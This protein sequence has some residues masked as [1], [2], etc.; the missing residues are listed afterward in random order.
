MTR[1]LYI[2][3]FKE[4]YSTERYIVHALEELGYEV[5]AKQ[6]GY[7]LIT[8]A[9]FMVQE[10]V[11]FNPALVMFSK[12]KPKGNS[13]GFIEGLKKKGIPTCSWLFDLYFDLPIDRAWRLRAKDAPFNCDVIYTTDGGHHK[14]F[15]ELGIT[16]KT[17][18]QGIHESEA[19]LYDREKTYDV[20]FVGGD[21]FKT[22]VEMLEGLANR[23]GKKFERFGDTPDNIVRN[24]PLNELYAST[25]V[26][27]GDSQPSP[28]Y[29]SNR[30]YETLGRGGFLLHPKTEGIKDEFTDGVHLVLYERGDLQDLYDK[31]DYYLTHDEEREKIR[32]AG[33]EHVKKNYTYKKRCIELMKNYEG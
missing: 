4:H 15:A 14:Q 26:V 22:R 19:I 27:V 13:Y 28:H 7:M 30:L 8:D 25:K 9:D 6:E 18:R 32:R 12:G 2:G 20:I 31:I 1:I 3:D 5:M 17:L 24:L 10:V 23:Y 21:G 11:E 33:F 16:S 29:W